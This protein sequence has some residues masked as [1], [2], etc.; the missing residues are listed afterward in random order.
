M[1]PTAGSPPAGRPASAAA[2]ASGGQTEPS[3]IEDSPHPSSGPTAGSANRLAGTDSGASRPKCH[4]AIGVVTSVQATD[5]ATAD[6]SVLCSRGATAKI[7]HT[8]A[9]LSWKPGLN[10]SSG[11]SASTTAAP[12]ASRCQRAAGRDASQATA[13]SAPATPARTI[14]G[15]APVT[16]T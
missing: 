8:A 4:Q 3:R 12:Q 9:K 11:F 5:T 16:S 1:P 10:R 15:P 14:E 13:T 7:A 2:S 6:P